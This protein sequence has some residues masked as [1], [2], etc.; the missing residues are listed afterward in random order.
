MSN[1]NYADV[2]IKEGTYP[3]PLLNLYSRNPRWYFYESLQHYDGCY[4]SK[5]RYKKEH[6]LTGPEMAMRSGLSRFKN[7]RH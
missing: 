4:E 1:G 3:G 5:Q 7:T 2:N 6:T